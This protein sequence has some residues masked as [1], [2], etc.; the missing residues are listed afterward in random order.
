MINKDGKF[1]PMKNISALYLSREE[2]KPIK[3]PGTGLEPVTRGFSEL[4]NY[5]H[6]TSTRIMLINNVWAVANQVGNVF[7]RQMIES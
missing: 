1:H 3:M 4:R 7:Y 5:D 2:K 6:T